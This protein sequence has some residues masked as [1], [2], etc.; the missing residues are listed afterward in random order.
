MTSTVSNKHV[1]TCSK[2][3]NHQ[4]SDKIVILH[5]INLSCSYCNSRLLSTSS[6]YSLGFSIDGELGIFWLSLFT[7]RFSKFREKNLKIEVSKK[8]SRKIFDFEKSESFPNMVHR[9]SQNSF[10]MGVSVQYCDRIWF[11][12]QFL[13]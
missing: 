5:L 2:M 9:K 3:T 4:K 8:F 6:P 10:W 7:F 13:Y 12:W 11:F 1:R